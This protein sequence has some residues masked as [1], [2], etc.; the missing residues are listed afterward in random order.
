MNKHAYTVYIKIARALSPPVLSPSIPDPHPRVGPQDGHQQFSAF[1]VLSI[2]SAEGAN[3][4]SYRLPGEG[5]ERGVYG[6]HA[7][8]HTNEHRASDL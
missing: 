7:H 5:G 1:L 6:A 2:L 8:R 4:V 3:G